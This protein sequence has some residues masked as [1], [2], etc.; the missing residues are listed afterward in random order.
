M[1]KFRK[2]LNKKKWF[3]GTTLSAWRQICDKRI[4]VK[5]NIGHELDFGYGFYL[6]NKR[7]QAEKY[8]SDLIKLKQEAPDLSEF[9]ETADTKE[10]NIPIVIE[11]EFCPLE[12][13]ENTALNFGIYNSYDDSF[14]E[15]VFHNRLNNINGENHHSYDV[16]FGVMSDSA[17]TTLILDYK[18]GYLGKEQVIEG[19]KKSTSNKQLTIHKQELCD[20]LSVSRVYCVFDGEELDY[21]E[22]SNFEQLKR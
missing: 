3:H 7:E 11:F 4:Q 18:K 20:K 5:H 1:G 9:L 2:H 10:D 16:I 17:P 21:S 22:Y 14:A 13:Y 15:F 8:I 19:L 12:W 6:T